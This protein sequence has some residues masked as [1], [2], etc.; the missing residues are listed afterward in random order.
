MRRT[1]LTLLAAS[2]LAPLAVHAQ[3]LAGAIDMHAHA[4]PDGEQVVVGLNQFQG[5]EERSQK[6]L[7]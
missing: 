5:E 1:M 4:A 7:S 2:L 3:T 6:V